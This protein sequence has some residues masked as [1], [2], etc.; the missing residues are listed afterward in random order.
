[1]MTVQSQTRV[2][3]SAVL[4]TARQ[5]GVCSSVMAA[6]S[7]TC[8]G[9]DEVCDK[10]VL[11]KAELYYQNTLVLAT[12]FSAAAVPVLMYFSESTCTGTFKY[13]HVTSISYIEST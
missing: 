9:N 2:P 11:L 6:M 8:I 4:S 10:F 7:H 1:M 3:T 13:F 5:I 12:P